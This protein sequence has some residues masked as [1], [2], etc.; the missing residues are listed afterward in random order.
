MKKLLLASIAGLALATGSA[1]AADLARPVYKAPPPPP[2]P[3]YSW[4]GCYIDGG[5]GYGMW[6]QDSYSETTGLVPLSVTTT[7]GGR[8]WF[9]QVGAGCDY[10]IAS[11]FLIGAF[12]D[13]DFMNLKGQYMDPLTGF[14]GQEKET[15]AWAVGGRLGYIALPGLLTYINGG[16]TEARFDQVNFGSLTTGAPIPFAMPATT[17]NGWFIGGGTETSLSGFFGLALPQGLFLRSEYRYSSFSAKDDPI[18]FTPTGAPFLDDHVNKYVQT[19]STS[20]VWKFNW[21]SPVAARY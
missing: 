6:N 3:S 1:S 21:T 17:Y 11:S 18:I 10:Q 9:G 19:I 5:A 12:G 20:L 7:F 14:V 16:Y 8:G 13:Y 15:G 4:T 2:P